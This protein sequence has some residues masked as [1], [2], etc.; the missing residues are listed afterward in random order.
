M[1]KDEMKSALLAVL[2]LVSWASVGSERTAGPLGKV[3]VGG[4]IG[5]RIAMTVTNNLMKLDY[6]RDFIRQF[7]AKD[8]KKSF[9]GT[10]NVIESLVALA[11][12]TG[13]GDVLALKR[14]LVDAIVAAQTP[15]GYIGC[16]PPDKRVWHRWDVEDIGF[17]LDGLVLDWKLFGE[18]RSLDAAVRAADQT[19][20]NWKD[21]PKDFDRIVY[22]KETLMG[23]AHGMW[24]LF[25][26]TGDRRYA[27]FVADTMGY[28]A[29][30]E[31]VRL[32]RDLGLRG[33]IDGYLDTCLTQLD[34]YGKTG[35]PRLLRQFNRFLRHF[36]NENGALIHGIEGICECFTGDQD[37]SGY[38]GETCMSAYLLCTLDAAI[39]VGAM[40]ASLAGDLMERTLY[41]AFFAAQSRDGRRLRYYT[42]VVGERPYWPM[43]D[44]CCP[45]NYRR[46]IGHL[47][48]FVFYASGEELLANLYTE[49]EAELMVAGT[50]VRVKETTDYPTTGTV[51]FRIDPAEE[52]DFSFALR[53]PRWCA[54]PSASVNGE[55]LSGLRPGA[56][57][58]IHRTWK[59][60]D[61][62]RAAFPMPVRLV[63][64]RARQQ[65]RF[66]VMRGPLVYAIDTKPLA[67]ERGTWAEGQ[68]NDAATAEDVM[69]VYPETLRVTLGDAAARK[70]GTAVLASVSLV[71]YQLGKDCG[72]ASPREVRLTEFA[73]PANT[74]TYFRVPDPAGCG[75]VDDELFSPCD[76]RQFTY[77]K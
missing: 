24:S 47:P 46:V 56:L 7:V 26:V 51:E 35:D 1:R 20:A 18:K 22:D 55:P 14:R 36:L 50:T 73:D 28:G 75:A 13:D 29:C 54:A 3:R 34:M 17:I 30:D 31:P 77:G 19:L 40:D 11:K 16:M 48:E 12:H 42:P 61:V 62:V 53:L 45:C 32:G 68:G 25:A 5:E 66:A 37:G 63:R 43:D 27:D 8:G 49:A 41:N 71:P 38:A 23:L 60:G 64:G 21:P 58:R 67:M 9:V 6:D 33:Q 69:V 15:E 2:A 44:Y 4:V 52:R 76:G 39:R 65:G 72:F 10:G 70:G 59:A 74:L 57:Q